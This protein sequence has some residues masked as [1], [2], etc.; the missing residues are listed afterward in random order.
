MSDD[1]GEIVQGRIA[2]GSPGHLRQYLHRHHE[3]GFTSSRFTEA[4]ECVEWP[5]DQHKSI[6]ER[7]SRLQL[8]ISHQ[9]VG[10][11]GRE[12][13]EEEDEDSRNL[14]AASEDV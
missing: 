14:Q 4:S 12:V 8:L 3:Q 13:Q 2:E 5:N 10:I 6:R 9:R 11:D 1:I 7:H